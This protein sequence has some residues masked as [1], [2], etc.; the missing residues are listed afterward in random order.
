MSPTRNPVCSLRMA[1]MLP[2]VGAALLLGGL[3][4][5]V[6]R[7]D[8]A[9]GGKSVCLDVNR[10]DHT[11]VLNDHQ[12][13]FHMVNGKIWQNNLTVPCRTLTAQDGFSWE[14]GIPKF[15]DNVEQIRVLRTGESCLLGPFVAYV[16]GGARPEGTSA[17]A[18]S[19]DIKP[20]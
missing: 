19:R 2:I 16:P 20:D 15:C 9:P 5:A 4:P 6:A 7:A 1:A 14:S 18:T 10:I 17:P 11:Q 8:N 12:I 13:L 3:S